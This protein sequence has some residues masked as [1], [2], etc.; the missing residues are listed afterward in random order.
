MAAWVPQVVSEEP[1]VMAGEEVN[2][3]REGQV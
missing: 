2:T 3:G 1:Q